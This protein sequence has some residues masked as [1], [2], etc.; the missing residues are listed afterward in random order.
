MDIKA[1]EPHVDCMCKVCGEYGTLEK[2]I[3]KYCYDCLRRYKIEYPEYIQSEQYYMY[4]KQTLENIFDK[5]KN[6]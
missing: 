5:P 3:G 1:I 2:N 6:T 4:M